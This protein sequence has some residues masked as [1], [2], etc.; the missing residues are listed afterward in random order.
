MVEYLLAWTQARYGAE[1]CAIPD[2]LTE[3]KAEPKSRPE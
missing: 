1:A 2:L 3:D